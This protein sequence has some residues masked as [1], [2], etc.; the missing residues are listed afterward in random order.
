MRPTRAVHAQPLNTRGRSVKL[1][2]GGECSPYDVCADKVEK[3][4]MI[5]MASPLEASGAGTSKSGARRG[6]RGQ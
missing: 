3:A 2:P 4:E 6:D 5:T 1:A